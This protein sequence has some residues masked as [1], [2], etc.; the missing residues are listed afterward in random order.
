MAW[1]TQG[2]TK[3]QAATSR[4]GRTRSP[5][6]TP[7]TSSA[8]SPRTSSSKSAIRKSIVG[9]ALVKDTFAQAAAIYDTLTFTHTISDGTHACMHWEA[10][11]LGGTWIGASTI[12]TTNDEGQIAHVVIW[13][14]PLDALLAFSNELG[15]RLE[16]RI[17]RDWFYRT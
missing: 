12:L 17:D 9:R 3:H 6:A 14:R 13:H 11:A 8:H 10:T 15:N 4:Y 16:G 7:L 2:Q 5:P 1:R